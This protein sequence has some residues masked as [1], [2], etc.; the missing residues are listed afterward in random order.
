MLM[1]TKIEEAKLSLKNAGLS[2]VTITMGEFSDKTNSI[3]GAK[4]AVGEL[5][6]NQLQMKAPSKVQTDIIDADKY[7]GQI[8]MEVLPAYMGGL[9]DRLRRYGSSC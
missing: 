4:H 8:S 3:A 6:Y 9:F 5:M 7:W 2:D 1:L